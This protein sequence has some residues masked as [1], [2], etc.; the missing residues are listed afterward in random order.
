MSRNLTAFGAA[1]VFSS[2][3]LFTSSSAFAIC[4]SQGLE[5]VR[6]LNGSWQG[7]GAVTPI[8]GA[9][10]RISCRITY[11]SDSDTRIKQVIAC[12]GTDYKIEASSQVTCVGSL[13][14][15]TFEE[16]VAHNSGIVKGSISGN[17]L[18]IEADGPSFKGTFN[19][20]FKG[21]SQH[22]VTIQQFDPAKGRKVPVASILLSR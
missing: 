18:D 1:A 5:L 6:N 11:S 22:T 8:G 14:E 2:L 13:L 20:L 19:V 15:G 17:H 16:A 3:A 9:A 21:E 7:R 12:A 10:E 4:S